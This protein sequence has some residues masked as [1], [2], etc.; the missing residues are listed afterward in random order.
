MSGA[1]NPVSERDGR[2][3]QSSCSGGGTGGMGKRLGGTAPGQG[4][5]LPGNSMQRMAHL[6]EMLVSLY[7]SH[8][9]A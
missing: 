7:D 1:L 8:P 2:D 6:S 4:A 5:Y 3:I 9:I